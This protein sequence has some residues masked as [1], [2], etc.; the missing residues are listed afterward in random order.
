MLKNTH[1]HR[2]ISWRVQRYQRGNQKL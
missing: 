2:P 1:L